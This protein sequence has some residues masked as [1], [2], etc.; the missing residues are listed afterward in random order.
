MDP[1]I[2]YLHAGLIGPMLL[3]LG[4]LNVTGKYTKETGITLI[5]ISSIVILSHIGLAISKSMK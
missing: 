1:A 2:N 5:V 3:A 4:V